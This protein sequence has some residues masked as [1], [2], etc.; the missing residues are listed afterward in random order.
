MQICSSSNFQIHPLALRVKLLTHE[1]FEEQSNKNF[2][3]NMEQMYTFAIF[4]PMIEFMY[5]FSLSLVVWFG[6]RLI[7]ENDL[8]IGGLLAFIFYIR[9]LFRPILEL[10]DKYNLLQSALGASDNLFSIITTK[11]NH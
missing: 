7:I 9:M 3:V 2:E 10:A 1:T 11:P 6:G 8:S 5:A 4:R